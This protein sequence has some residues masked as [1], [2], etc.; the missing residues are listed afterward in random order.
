MWRRGRR[1]RRKI[2]K[3]EEKN[4]MPEVKRRR[5]TLVLP[6]IALCATA[7]EASAQDACK[8]MRKVNVGVAVA[9]PNV[10]HTAPYVAKA[11]GYFA[12]FCIDADIIQFEGGQSQ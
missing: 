3:A 4:A 5:W 7:S 10:V 11:L 9:P 1:R 8:T 12:K 2:R 6:L